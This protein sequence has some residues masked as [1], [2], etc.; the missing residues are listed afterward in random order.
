[1]FFYL[2]AFLNKYAINQD[3][4]KPQNPFVHG[5]LGIPRINHSFVSQRMQA[6]F[7]IE[8]NVCQEIVKML[9]EISFT[10]IKS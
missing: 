2:L 8:T 1:M 5:T 4:R 7:S 9:L 3:R 6:T 10:E